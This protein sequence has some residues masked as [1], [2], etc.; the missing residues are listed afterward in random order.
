MQR[1]EVKM[2]PVIV[3]ENYYQNIYITLGEAIH[4]LMQAH[5][6]LQVDTLLYKFN[7]CCESHAQCMDVIQQFVDIIQQ[8]EA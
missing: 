8:R 2:K 3:I 1:K 4:E 7:K 5:Q 6:E